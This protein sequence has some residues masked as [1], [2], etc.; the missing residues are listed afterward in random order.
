MNLKSSN[1]LNI[2]TNWLVILT[3]RSSSTMKI[4]TFKPAI[5]AI[6]EFIDANSSKLT[7]SQTNTLLEI[8]RRLERL[9]IQVNELM[10]INEKLILKEGFE[11]NFDSSM[12]TMTVSFAGQ[13]VKVQLRR[14][15]PN[16]PITMENL[17]RGSAYHAGNDNSIDEEEKKLRI[18][19]EDKLESYYYS[20]HK[21]LKLLGT[22]PGLS[23]IKSISVTRVRNNLIEH[24]S[25]GASYT[26]GVGSTGPRVKP[27]YQGEQVFNDEGL[28]PNTGDLISAIVEGCKNVSKTR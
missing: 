2:P 25:D 21:V 22:V 7:P 19:L 27:M 1:T 13:E 28:L 5:E 11:T 14:A 9:D 8:K 4:L 10:E 23:K 18:E 24:T 12:D 16:V 20:A 26:F 17:T 3:L 6:S 15:D